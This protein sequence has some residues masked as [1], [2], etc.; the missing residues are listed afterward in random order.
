MKISA[1]KLELKN[2]KEENETLKGQ[3]HRNWVNEIS[4]SC[5]LMF[6]YE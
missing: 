4:L 3:V 6:S 2:L 5:F 1:L